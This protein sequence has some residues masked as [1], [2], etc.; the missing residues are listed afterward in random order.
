ML[1]ENGSFFYFL[2]QDPSFVFSQM[3]ELEDELE[4]RTLT[5]TSWNQSSN[6][7]NKQNWHPMTFEY[8]DAGPQ[9]I[10]EIRVHTIFDGC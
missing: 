5:Y 3:N 4:R 9:H 6:D 2:I 7:K 10:K 8:A 1:S